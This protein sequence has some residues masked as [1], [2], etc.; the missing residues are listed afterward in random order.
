MVRPALE[1]VSSP[2]GLFSDNDKA[3]VDY[4]RSFN[5]MLL[6]DDHLLILWY[7]YGLSDRYRLITEIGITRCAPGAGSGQ[8]K[9]SGQGIKLKRHGLGRP[10]G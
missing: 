6:V 8:V 4:E 3:T 10:L 1:C 2:L 5:D 9:L 7:S